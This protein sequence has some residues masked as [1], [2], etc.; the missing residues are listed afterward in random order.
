MK[1]SPTF[2]QLFKFFRIKS[3]FQTISHFANIFAEKGFA[4]DDSLFSHWQRGSRVPTKR[5]LVL[6]LIEVFAETGSIRYEDQANLLLKSAKANILTAEEKEKLPTLRLQQNPLSWEIEL[7]QFINTSNINKK[8][9]TSKNTHKN[10]NFRFNFILPS[11]I[12]FYFEKAS[13][14]DCSSKADFL[15]KLIESHKNT[16]SII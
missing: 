1:V 11:D 2:A 12:F 5:E 10:K 8:L 16:N 15:R 4:Y 13:K 6:T 14:E 7:N 9:K 3:G